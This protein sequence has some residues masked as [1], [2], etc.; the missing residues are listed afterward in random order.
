MTIQVYILLALVLLDAA[1]LATGGLGITSILLT[2][3]LACCGVVYSLK[4]AVIWRLRNRLIVTY[5]FV[6]V[7]PILLVIALVYFGTYLVVGQVATYLVSSELHRRAAVLESPARFLAQAPPGVR[8]V[9]MEQMAPL[10]RDRAPR[11]EIVVTGDGT[12]FRYPPDSELEV[13]PAGWGKYTGLVVKNGR[14]CSMAAVSN[15]KVRALVMAPL[16]AGVL[17]GLV[18]GIGAV[19]LRAESDREHVNLR[20]RFG[21]TPPPAYNF[22]DSEFSWLNPIE[23]ADWNQ[24]NSRVPAELYVNT[25][26]S[27]VLAVI[28]S[29]RPDVPLALFL[30]LLGGVCI[31]AMAVSVVIGVHITRTIT[32]AVHNLYE[33]TLRIAHGDFTHRIPVRGKDQLA[34]LGNSFNQMTAEVQTLLVVAKEKERLQSEL[35]IASEVQNQLFPKAAPAMR[36]IELFGTCNPA[37][38]VSGDYYDYVCLPDGNLALAIGDVAGKGISAAL[39]M[40]STQSILRTQLAAGVPMTAAVGGAASWSH[41]STASIV[42]QL[43]RQLYANTAPE[44]YATFFFGL[45]D[46]NSRILTY[47]NAGHL[48]PLLVCGGK[49]TELEVTGTVV[50]LF[51][52]IQYE[53]QSIHLCPSDLLVAYTDGMTEPENAYGEEFGIERLTECVLK[54]Q[55]CEPCEIVAKVMESVQQWSNAP[56]LPDD[57]TVLVARGL[58]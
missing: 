14:Y 57:M 13:L 53:E 4:A 11:F 15:G 1:L 42:A 27:A 46:Q 43:N 35:T 47:T 31:I 8:G 38:T 22:L 7:V 45:Y 24:P 20:A 51:P 33:G 19:G 58:A 49:V 44:K 39:L 32:G 6:G 5:L 41:F 48:P 16:D 12:T 9:I 18:P 28:F 25:R 52:S 40:A 29:D 10:L 37:R 30:I 26:T 23:V 55:V 17:E 36:T 2:M 50:G 21:G 54:H 56:E 3:A 34:D